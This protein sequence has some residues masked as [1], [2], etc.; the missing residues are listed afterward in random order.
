MGKLVVGIIFGGKSGE[1]E[2]SL[3]SSANVIDA[4]DKNKYEIVQIGISKDGDWYLYHGE[5]SRI[6]DGTWLKDKENIEKNFSVFTHPVVETVDVFFPVLHGPNGEDGT[7][8]GLL[9]LLDKPYVGCGVL[10]SS[11]GMDKIYSKVLF[12]NAGIPTGPYLSVYQEEWF[13]DTDGVI[14]EIEDKLGYPFFIKPANMGS[15]VGIS[16][17]HS[18]S[19]INEGMEEAFMHDCK[20]ILEKGI[21]CREVECAVLG[22]R[23]A[24]SSIAG[25]IIPSKEFYDYQAKYFDDG[26][27]VLIIPAQLED[28]IMDRIKNYAV[29]AFESI[30]GRG[31][32]RVDFFIDKDNGEI[33]IN[34]I[35]TMPGFTNISMYPKLWEVSGISYDNLI[36]R[37]IDLAIEEYSNRK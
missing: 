29:K 13:N 20:L 15:S 35:N 12:E 11:V 17:I 22:N 9:T 6:K 1:H 14:N 26:Q 37:L 7:I 25:E 10:A 4:M 36:E 27:S 33:Y 19:E 24:K 32:A 2:V 34:E 5:T 3:M 21:N 16:K 23:Y 28:D 30:N 8:Q 18:P 31:L